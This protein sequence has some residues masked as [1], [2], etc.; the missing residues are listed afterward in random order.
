MPSQQDFADRFELEYNA[1]EYRRLICGKEVVLHCHH[2]NSR[3]Q[4]SLESVSQVD[5]K[6][7]IRSAAEVV[8]AD[9]VSRATRPS[10]SEQD[11]FAVAQALYSHL[12]FGQLDFSDVANGVVTASTAHFVEGW[13]T[14][15]G[16]REEPVCTFTEGYIQGVIKAVTGAVVTVRETSCLISGHDQCRFEIDPDRRAPFSE[17][18]EFSSQFTA[19][20]I[21][22][23]AQS[24]NVDEQAIIN[25]VVGLPIYGDDEGLIP[26]FS[27]YLACMPPDFYNLACYTFVQKME[28]QNLHSTAKNLLIYCGE[29]CGTA[30]FQGIMASEEW[31]GLVAPMIK[32]PS[33]NVFALVA[34][35]NAFGWGNW[36]V[37]EHEPHRTLAMESL[38]GYEALG[39]RTRVGGADEPRCYMLTGV[40]AGMMELIYSTGTIADRFGTFLSDETTCICCERESCEFEVESA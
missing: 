37:R 24:E 14:I 32:R 20:D 31:A 19:K 23:F 26:V 38:N 11:K 8:F 40:S 6:D 15:F 35:S 21:S 5:G 1:D 33:D 2:Y 12:G 27:V 34:I 22:G 39:H 36:H 9:H 4:H 7:I 13:N 30:T 18:P 16:P 17:F 28:Q 25:A 29:V 10:D 3:L